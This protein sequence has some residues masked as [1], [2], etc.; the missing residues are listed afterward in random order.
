MRAKKSEKFLTSRK[1]SDITYTAS[2][3][4]EFLHF[5]KILIPRFLKINFNS[6]VK[7][8]RKHGG[9]SLI[10]CDARSLLV[11]MSGMFSF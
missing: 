9:A 2:A 4:Q 7:D 8:K 5:M 6:S 3:T 1:T 10:I 11:V